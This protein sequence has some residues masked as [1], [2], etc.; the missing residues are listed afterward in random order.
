[1]FFF[2]FFIDYLLSTRVSENQNGSSDLDALYVTVINFFYNKNPTL[3]DNY[4]ISQTLFFSMEKEFSRF[5]NFGFFSDQIPLKTFYSS[6]KDETMFI[7]D[8]KP[9]FT[10]ESTVQEKLLFFNLFAYFWWIFTR[11]NKFQYLWINQEEPQIDEETVKSLFDNCKKDFS[12][13]LEH[14]I[15]SNYLL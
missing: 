10:K 3:R 12:N 9:N 8:G 4:F 1:M 7:N 2:Y 14:I 5:F 11:K 13:Q 6:K 15:L